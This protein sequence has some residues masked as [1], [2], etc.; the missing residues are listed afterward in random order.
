M[1]VS[2]SS[3]STSG[4][5]SC[6]AVQF[7]VCYRRPGQ[8]RSSTNSPVLA[9][10]GASCT[11]WPGSC[12]VLR[13]VVLTGYVWLSLG[14]HVRCGAEDRPVLR[15]EVEDGQI[16]LGSPRACERRCRPA[17]LACA[18]RV[19]ACG[20]TN[21]FLVVLV[22]ALVALWSWW[23]RIL[24]LLVEDSAPDENHA[25]TLSL[26]AVTASTDVVFLLGGIVVESFALPSQLREI[27][28]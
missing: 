25:S 13:A 9:R 20:L 8:A 24:G 6:G 17:G 5:W 26:L 23:P 3:A 7:V 18:R 4:S 15:T 27:S 19:P 21:S 14:L 2:P 11:V 12:P 28:G 16:R 10:G 22:W 1:V